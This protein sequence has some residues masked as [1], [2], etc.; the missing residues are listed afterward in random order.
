VELVPVTSEHFAAEFPSVRPRSE[1]MR[2]LVLDL[3]GMNTMR[4]WQEALEEYLTVN[5]TDL[6]RAVRIA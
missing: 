2:N 6:V 4:P 5:F 3:Q 1:I